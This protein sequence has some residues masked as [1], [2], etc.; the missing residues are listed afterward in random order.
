[1]NEDQF[2][3]RIKQIFAGIRR[4]EY[5]S[6]P[7]ELHDAFHNNV[8]ARSGG[9]WDEAIAAQEVQ[10]I[11]QMFGVQ[12]EAVTEA[13]SVKE[14]D[15][16][17]ALVQF[18]KERGYTY[19]PI[20]VS[21]AKTPDGYI[22]GLGKKYLCE[23]KSPELKYD[24]AAAPFGY[25]FATSH[26][27]ILDFIHKAIKQFESQDTKHELPHILIYT[28]AHPLLHWKSFLDAIQG[29]VID[30]KG[31]W[32]PD[33]SSTPIYKS[34]LPLI[35]DIDLYVWFQ[36]GTTNKSFNQ[37]SF[38]IN[39]TS[40]YKDECIELIGTLSTTKVSSMDNII[41]LTST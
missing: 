36:I 35:M 20:K 12:P 17:A 11:E 16:I 29:G 30:Q 6:T 21:S 18:L 33:L 15:V 28:S 5:D 41:W 3:K 22:D 38:F 4:A 19:T 27:K 2:R 32:S 23:V 31:N 40:K 25:K 8:L 10:Q 24:H 26:R 14:T 13:A 9:T 39:Q 34:T 7:T 37:A 1:M